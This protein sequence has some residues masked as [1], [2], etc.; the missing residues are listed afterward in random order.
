MKKLLF[1]LTLA[2]LAGACSK[3]K[4]SALQPSRTN[5][6]SAAIGNGKAN[7]WLDQHAQGTPASLGFTLSKGALDQLPATLPGTDYVLALPNEVTQK[8][9]FQYIMI[10]WNPP[11]HEPAGIY[12]VPHFD[13][14]FYMMPANEVMQ[15]PPYPQNPAAFDNNPAAACLP[16]GYVKSPGGVPAM[17]AHWSDPT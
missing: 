7:A 16:A 9:S 3:D 10:N 8:T 17:G 1:H 13:F 5:G 4:D 6:P 15:I 12:D 14:H 11:G 2:S